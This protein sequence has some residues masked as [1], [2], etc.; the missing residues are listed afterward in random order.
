MD[1][2]EFIDERYQV[3]RDMDVVKLFYDDG[4][5]S[6]NKMLIIWRVGFL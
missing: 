4:I 2:V 1:L 5:A 3:L 6:L